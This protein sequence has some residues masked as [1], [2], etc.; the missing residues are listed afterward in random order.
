LEIIDCVFTGGAGGGGVLVGTCIGA[1]TRAVADGFG[2]PRA[3]NWRNRSARE[4]DGA[5]D[6]FGVAAEP[7]VSSA[8][9]GTKL[10]RGARV[11]SAVCLDTDG[12]ADAVESVAVL[13]E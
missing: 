12:A 3:S 5:D 8:G 10:V 11:P 2:A 1:V 7:V 4:I 6:V 13:T 9:R